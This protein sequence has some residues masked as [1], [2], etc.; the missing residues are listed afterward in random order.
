MFKGNEIS[1]TAALYDSSMFN[2]TY[3]G[4]KRT[5]PNYEKAKAQA[6]KRIPQ[7][8]FHEDQPL[9]LLS[10]RTIALERGYTLVFGKI[11]LLFH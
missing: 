3:A 9:P 6:Y 4:D 8:L 1:F 7:Y 5:T 11:I 2:A 10:Y